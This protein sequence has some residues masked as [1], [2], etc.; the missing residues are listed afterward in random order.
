MTKTLIEELE[1][2]RFCDDCRTNKCCCE[3]PKGNFYYSRMEVKFVEEV[4]K[5]KIKE[6]LADV[7][8]NM[9]ASGFRIL[10]QKHFGV[11]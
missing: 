1:K 5:N 9:N 4:V 8:E 10:L 6:C 3:I 2:H 7:Q 11:K